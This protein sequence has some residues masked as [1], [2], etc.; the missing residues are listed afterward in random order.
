MKILS[1]FFNF[2][3]NNIKSIAP[4]IDLGFFS[5]ENSL[6]NQKIH[7]KDIFYQFF[8]K[9][10]ILNLP[11]SG[12]EIGTKKQKLNY[13][14]IAINSFKG[15]LMNQ[16]SKL[17]INHQTDLQSIIK[18]FGIPYFTDYCDNET[19]MF[20]EYKKGTIELQFEFSNNNLTYISFMANGVLSSE[21]QRKLYN[22]NKEWP[23]LF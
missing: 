5:V 17:D 13:V 18:L 10:K 1:F 14:I 22:V 16:E 2:S 8:K 12:I 19:I 7:E 11:G 21:K 20:Y 23:P 4:K 15:K 6:I 9:K 3:K